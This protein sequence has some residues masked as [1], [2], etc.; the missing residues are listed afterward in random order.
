MKPIAQIYTGAMGN[1]VGKVNHAC[2]P[3]AEFPGNE[4]IGGGG[5][6]CSSQFGTYYITTK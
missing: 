5:G 6:K 3:S 2:D 1:W 4:D